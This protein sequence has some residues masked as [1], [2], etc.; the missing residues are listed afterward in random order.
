[1]KRYLCRPAKKILLLAFLVFF[2][3][4]PLVRAE[5]S[6]EEVKDLTVRIERATNEFKKK[7]DDELKR[8]SLLAGQIKKQVAQFESATDKLRR[9]AAG[10]NKGLVKSLK[11]RADVKDVRDEGEGVDKI[12][13]IGKWDS[14]TKLA[15]AK[16]RLA[17]NVLAEKYELDK[18]NEK[19]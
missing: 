5:L 16:L 13:R 12:M 7:I 2:V 15:W 4:A 6:R 11:I 18:I 19:D 14:G 3:S 1:M 17:V 8:S 10:D 9:E